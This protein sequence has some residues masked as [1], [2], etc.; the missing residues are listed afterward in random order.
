MSAAPVPDACGALLTSEQCS[1][2]VS[3]IR[4]KDTKP[5]LAV[6]RAL[7]ALEYRYRIATGLPG[8]PG[9]VFVRQQVAAFIDG[10]FW[11]RCPEHFLMLRYSRA[12]WEAKITA[13]TERDRR[14]DGE[15]AGTGW[16]ELRFWEHEVRREPVRMV[17]AVADSPRPL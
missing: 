10:C 12:F 15:L 16:R 14:V 4:G 2:C 8:R 1:R 11:L 5:E 17:E 13:N 3:R 9:L 6:R 7:P